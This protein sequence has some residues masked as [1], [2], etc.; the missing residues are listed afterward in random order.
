MIV[1]YEEEKSSQL[2]VAS[3]SFGISFVD[4]TWS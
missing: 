3:F 4:E 1:I 2:M